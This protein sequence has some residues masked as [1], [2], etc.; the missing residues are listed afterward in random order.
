MGHRPERSL[1]ED[2]HWLMASQ[3]RRGRHR[4]FIVFDVCG[5][6]LL[7]CLCLGPRN[8]GRP[9]PNQT[10]VRSVGQVPSL[11]HTWDAGLHMP[12]PVPVGW[13]CGQRDQI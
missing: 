7:S 2:S 9:G 6:G 11:T 13:D 4:G 3:R 8:F 5:V 1:A 10:P 12:Q